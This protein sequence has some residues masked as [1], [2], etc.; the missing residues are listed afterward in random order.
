MAAPLRTLLFAPGNDA[1]KAAQALA[2]PVLGG[3]P[4]PRGR[5][6]AVREGWPRAAR[7]SRPSPA[8]P[9]AP[10][11]RRARERRWRPG[12]W[13]TTSTPSRRPCRGSTSSWCRWST[14]RTTCGTSP[15]GSTR[16][17]APPAPSPVACG[18][19]RWPRRPPGSS[20]RPPS[21]PRPSAC[22]TLLLRACRPG[23]RARRSS[24]P[25]TARSCAT[26]ARRWCS[27]RARPAA[28]RRSTGRTSTSPTTRA[29]ASTR[30]WSRRL[31]FQG[32]LVIHP[33]QIADRRRG[34]PARRGELERAR[35]IVEA[36]DAALADGVASIRLDGRALRRRAD[37]R[38]RPRAAGATRRPL[39]DDGGR[40]AVRGSC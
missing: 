6:G 23:P 30:S 39:R 31:G 37:R 32:K 3:V 34:L 18:C 22:E 9:P 5:R 12:C 14:G 16:W 13:T 10:Q 15:R 4:R 24:S 38:P 28:P 20:P 2:A 35:A 29:A 26:P 1:R 25:P 17:S 27:R 8:R 11:R 19:W 33:R 7:S 21:R 40:R 36:Y